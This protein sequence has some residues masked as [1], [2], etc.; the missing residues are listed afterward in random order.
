MREPPFDSASRE[1]LR[2]SSLSCVLVVNWAFKGGF[3]VAD[4]SGR[5]EWAHPGAR[6]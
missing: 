1:T 6:I 4:S 3:D 5:I 2:H